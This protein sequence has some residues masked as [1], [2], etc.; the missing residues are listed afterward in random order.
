MAGLAGMKPRILLEEQESA[1]STNGTPRSVT[2][3]GYEAFLQS[4][5][6]AGS[7]DS[8]AGGS[9]DLKA[10]LDK[11]PS[12][13]ALPRGRLPSF[14][15]ASDDGMDQEL[16]DLETS[17]A[18]LPKMVNFDDLGL[19]FAPSPATAAAQ[20]GGGT[21]SHASET[22][23]PSLPAEGH[24]HGIIK[25]EGNESAAAAGDGHTQHQQVPSP[26]RHSDASGSS[27][28][29]ERTPQKQQHH[30]Q[31]DN[32]RRISPSQPKPGDVE[33]PQTLARAEVARIQLAEMVRRGAKH[34]P[35]FSD[36]NAAVALSWR[37]LTKVYSGLVPISAKGAP[38]EEPR[39]LHM[40]ECC[41][42][43]DTAAATIANAFAK[44][45]MDYG[46]DLRRKRGGQVLLSVAARAAADPDSTSP[47]TVPD[48]ETATTGAATTTTTSAAAEGWGDIAVVDAQ[49]VVSRPTKHRVL[50]VRLLEETAEGRAPHTAPAAAAAGDAAAAAEG[51]G[52]TPR[53]AL[54]DA[55]PVAAV[56]LDRVR[57]ELLHQGLLN[58]ALAAAPP[59]PR[60]GGQAAEPPL[61]ADFVAQLE[62]AC[63]TDLSTALGA[64]ARQLEEFLEEQE[65]RAER[66]AAMLK[67]MFDLYRMPFPGRAAE[68]LPRPFGKA[69]VAAALRGLSAGEVRELSRHV[70]KNEADR[71]L[72]FVLARWRS[73]VGQCDEEMSRAVDT[74]NHQALDRLLELRMYLCELMQALRDE[75]ASAAAECI[76]KPFH[77]AI[78]ASGIETSVDPDVE[79]PIFFCSVL[80][81]SWPGT[82]YLTYWHLCLV[83]SLTGFRPNVVEIPL[84]HVSQ[85]EA[86]RMWWGRGYV[87]LQLRSGE[88]HSF[89]P[90]ALSATRLRDM[91][92]CVIDARR[93]ATPNT[94]SRGTA[95]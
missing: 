38:H 27:S 62:E 21:D 82:M 64:F 41:V 52:R 71:V 93:E 80:A 13:W 44:L 1:T 17:V 74:L 12:P 72:A 25:S 57:A 87:E 86:H 70:F 2:S 78:V 34:L 18:Q 49:L 59:R 95:V 33:S 73:Y 67:P 53:D 79:G 91:L 40:L 22:G 90:T 51:D 69:P 88:S 31:P 92:A 89:T 8:A 85:V 14:G 20:A 68:E 28:S 60:A 94:L 19:A 84:R 32:H 81:G 35:D 11:P 48:S 63:R 83:T 5:T 65:R 39:C 55:L 45:A 54:A 42:R 77:R 30:H 37:V 29:E 6:S 75:H 26:R 15:D 16:K 58:S 56:F 47:G 61:D 3:P 50:L 36:C 7:W 10:A 76:T 43:A 66:A 4:L 9:F 24:A 23:A 46:M